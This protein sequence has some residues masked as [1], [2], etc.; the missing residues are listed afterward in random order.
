[1]KE[2]R[3]GGE[4]ERKVKKEGEEGAVN[5]VRKEKRKGGRRRRKERT[6]FLHSFTIDINIQT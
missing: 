2:G 1:M 5:E 3:R 4:G 6:D